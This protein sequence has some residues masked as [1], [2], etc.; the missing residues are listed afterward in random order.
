MIL[1]QGASV[2]E[3]VL[4][5]MVHLVES[6]QHECLISAGLCPSLLNRMRSM[7]LR[8][9]QRIAEMKVTM[10]VIIDGEGLT[11]ALDAIVDVN[12]QQQQFEAFIK[13]GASLPMLRSLFRVDEAQIQFTRAA[14][15]IVKTRGRPTLPQDPD[16]RDRIY[17]EWQTTIAIA[18]QRVR[19]MALANKYPDYRYDT[20]WA[21]INRFESGEE[22]Q[23]GGGR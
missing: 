17:S 10:Q 21:I 7:S 1:L 23:S 9:A 5:H 15:N 20:L 16:L 6:G 4:M 8:D 3:S 2:R 22:C 18:D 11:K 19:F 14:L 13:G 12:N